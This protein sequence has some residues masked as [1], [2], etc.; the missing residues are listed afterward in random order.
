MS[1]PFTDMSTAA[2]IGCAWKTAEVMKNDITYTASSGQCQRAARVN[3]AMN[4]CI[5]FLSPS[6]ELQA[7]MGQQTDRQASERVK[8]DN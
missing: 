1:T 8:D 4:L 7:A 3:A 2:E 5:Y 6:L